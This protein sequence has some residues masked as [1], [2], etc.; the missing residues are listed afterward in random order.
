MHLADTSVRLYRKRDGTVSVRLRSFLMIHCKGGN[1]FKLSAYLNKLDGS[2][3][4]D[5]G[6]CVIFDE[7]SYTESCLYKMEHMIHEF[8]A[9]GTTNMSVIKDGAGLL[10]LEYRLF[11][12]EGQGSPSVI[13][14][15]VPVLARG[16]RAQRWA[17]SSLDAIQI[18]KG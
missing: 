11:S 12:F 15:I 3:T 18:P 14:A 17:T 5:T 6:E 7:L 4:L 8:W 16:V 10:R 1:G 2:I 13:E 9:S